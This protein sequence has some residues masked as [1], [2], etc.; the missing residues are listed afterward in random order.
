M[1]LFKFVRDGANDRDVVDPGVPNA[2]QLATAVKRLTYAGGDHLF[3]S[4]L[5]WQFVRAA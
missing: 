2:G 5:R 4:R 3:C 1:E